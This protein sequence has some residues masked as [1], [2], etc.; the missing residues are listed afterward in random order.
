MKNT[1]YVING[2]IHFSF[3]IFHFLTVFLLPNSYSIGRR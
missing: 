3:F 1:A 2:I